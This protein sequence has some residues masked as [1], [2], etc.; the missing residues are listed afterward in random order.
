[1]IFILLI[2]QTGA[3][4]SQVWAFSTL[5]KAWKFAADRIITNRKWRQSPDHFRRAHNLYQ[6]KLYRAV[7]DFAAS[8]HIA[9]PQVVTIQLDQEYTPDPIPFQLIFNG[10]NNLKPA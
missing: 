8:V 9:Y 1:M 4:K 3:D 7:C 10:I 5:S 2:H 6:A